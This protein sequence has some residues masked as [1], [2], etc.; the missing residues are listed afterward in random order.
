MGCRPAKS[1]GADDAP[2]WLHGHLHD[3][4]RATASPAQ[5]DTYLV[6]NGATGAWTAIVGKIAEC[7]VRPGPIHAVDGHGISLPDGRIFER[8][9]GVYTEFLASRSWVGSERSG[10]QAQS[11]AWL[12]VISMT[13]TARSPIP[14]SGDTYLIP[15]GATGVWAANTGKIAEYLDGAW[16]YAA[17]VDGHGISLPDGRIF[18]RIGGVFTEGLASRSWVGQPHGCHTQTQSLAM[19]AGHLHDPDAPPASPVQ[20]DTYLVPTGATGVWETNTGKIAEYLDGAWSYATQAMAT[21]YLC[22]MALIR[23]HWR[24]SIPI[25]GKPRVGLA[26]ARLQRQSST[27]CRGCRHIMTLTAPPPAPRR[28]MPIWC[29]PAQ[30][31]L[32]G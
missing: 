3:P 14:H 32:G 10:D 27:A 28:A 4:D 29:R 13:T 11:S 12:P 23:T 6:P 26:A 17:P 8:I 21:A 1:H 31:C 16:S 22:Q 2:A 7:P 5:G 25:S 18:E 30:Q 15:T 24:L 20:G 9:G 19:V